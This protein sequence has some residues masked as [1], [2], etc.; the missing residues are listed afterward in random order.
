M[1]YLN[2]PVLLNFG[3]KEDK[4]KIGFGGYVGYRVGGYSMEKFSRRSEDKVK[5]DFGMNDF[6]YGV[7][8]EVGKKNGM[9]LFVRYDMNKLFKE[10][11]TA[12][13]KFLDFFHFS[14]AK[15]S[16]EPHETTSLVF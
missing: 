14:I 15:L 9:T 5:G 12:V 11:Q 13:F 1:P 4:F 3:F 8:A 6:V 16:F 10:S 7:T 2:F